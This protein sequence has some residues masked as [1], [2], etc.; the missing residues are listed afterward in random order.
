[1]HLLRASDSGLEGA[2]WGRAY[3]GRVNS[4]HD[5]TTYDVVAIGNAIVDVLA[6]ATDEELRELGLAKGTMSLIDGEAAERVYA[7]MGPAVE[8]SGGSAANTVAGIAALGGRA[9]FIGTVAD[10]Q[11]GQV[12]A[13][14]IRAAGVSFDS[15]PLYGGEP[16]ARC[17]I[18]VTPDGQRTMQTF[19]GAA[20][21]LSPRQVDDALVRAAQVLYLE[22]YLWDQPP[23][24]EAFRKAA[25]A[26]KAAGRKVSLTLSDPFCV[27]RHREEF[28]E[29]IDGHVDILFAN[30][31]EIWSLYRVADF[32]AALQRVRGH[33]EVAALTRSEKG[34][35]VVS[36]DEV[37]VVDAAPVEKVVDTTGAGDAYAAGF[38][39]GYTQG[40]DLRVCAQLGALTAAEVISH[41]GARPEADLREITAGV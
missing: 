2:A 36:G 38:L 17:L 21:A 29:L 34:S 32:D 15:A 8:M 30:E 31:A 16:T 3:H 27:E 18:L 37:H 11:L 1:M 33:C 35:V 7:A 20:S 25:A 22:G 41:Y 10:D 26:A 40:R 28:L 14:D 24:M 12:F 39:Y 5:A 4:S 23:A 9:A 6:Q 19:L 13:H